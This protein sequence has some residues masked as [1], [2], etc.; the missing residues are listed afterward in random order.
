MDETPSLDLLQQPRGCGCRGGLNI[1]VLIVVAICLCGLGPVFGGTILFEQVWFLPADG[2]TF[3]PIANLDAVHDFAGRDFDLVAIDAQF[4]RSDG[5][6]D[7]Y[8]SYQPNIMYRFAREVAG[9]SGPIGTSSNTSGIQYEI[10][11]VEVAGPTLRSS[12]APE[13][14]VQFTPFLGMDR[15]QWGPADSM[16]GV[17]MP[18]PACDFARLWS[19]ALE[20][21]APAEAVAIIHYARDHYEFRIEGTTINLRF[22][23][24]C[25]LTSR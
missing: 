11:Q 12:P 16:P 4:V 25:N 1:L 22:D 7:L 3:D 8:A 17:F 6:M 20:M 9:E 19:T 14:G 13:G 2:S 23:L 21:D 5:T 18:E 15:D 24:D 10:V